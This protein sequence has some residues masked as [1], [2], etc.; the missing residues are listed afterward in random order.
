MTVKSKL[1]TG[2]GIILLMVITMGGA[3]IW[4]TMRSLQLIEELGA[5]SRGAVQ[6]ANA[7]NALWQLRYGFPQFMLYNDKEARD[8]IVAD[9]AKWYKEIDDNLAAFKKGRHSAEELAA[10]KKLEDVFKQYKDARP[11]WFQLYGEWKLEEAAEWHAK[12]TTPYGAGTVAG[13]SELIQLQQK[14][15]ESLEKD[16]IKQ[17][18][19]LIIV[20]VVLVV[21]TI[22]LVL[23]VSYFT[24]RSISAP[25]SRALALAN[26]VAAGDLTAQIEVNSSDEFGKL[27]GALKAMNEN[28]TRMVQDIRGGAES[29]RTAA[30]EVA[31]GNANLS[32][33]TEEQASTLEETASSM[34]ELT[35]AVRENTQGA[36][37]ANAL[38]N[39]ANQVAAQ[40]GTVVGA[41]VTTMNEIQESSKK[42]GDIIGVIDSIAFQTNILAL[43]AAVEAA[44]AGEQGRGFAVVATEVRALAQRSADAAKEIKILIGNSVQKVETGTRQV[45]DAGKTMS[46]IVASV[47]KVTAIINQISSASREQSSGIEQVN[48]AIGQMDQVVQQ[49]AAV[50]EQAAAAAESMQANA[51]LLYQAVSVFK[52]DGMTPAKPAASDRP[53]A[54]APARQNIALPQATKNIKSIG[55]QPEAREGEWKEF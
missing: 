36:N 1:V 47:E 29:I 17:A 27:L 23:L 30:E 49:N 48:Q 11:R 4:N 24:I 35:A 52:L 39:E 40:G 25:L 55:A 5:S 37:N 41:V 7:Q 9:E 44:R 45:E 51:Q 34:E 20:L 54:Q 8:K 50:V 3:G 6:L 42:I 19:T 21:L 28:L 16:A 18:A 10:L 33:R 14:T 13:L 26:Q 15:A 2:L 53:Q 43:N 32:Q 38:A 31:S 46:E 22:V 12:T